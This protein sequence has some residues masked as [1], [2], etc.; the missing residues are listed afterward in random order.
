MCRIP[1][2]ECPFRTDTALIYDEI[3]EESL[4]EGREPTCHKISGV[5]KVFDDPSPTEVTICVGYV[6]WKDGQPGYEKP[7]I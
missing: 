2:S 5:D 3:A 7:C 6:K 1:C 4:N